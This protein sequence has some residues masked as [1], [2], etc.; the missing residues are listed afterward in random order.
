MRG[1]AGHVRVA[2]ILGFLGAEDNF[3]CAGMAEDSDGTLG[4]GTVD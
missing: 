1:Q 2:R 3:S 4:H